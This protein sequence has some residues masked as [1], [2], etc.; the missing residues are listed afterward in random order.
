M[1]RGDTEQSVSKPF[2]GVW[3]CTA[4]LRNYPGCHQENTLCLNERAKAVDGKGSNQRG[5]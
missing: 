5:I 1:L 4:G 3:L 2:E